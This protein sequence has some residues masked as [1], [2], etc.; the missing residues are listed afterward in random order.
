MNGTKS[1][2]EAPRPAESKATE[3]KAPESGVQVVVDWDS[4][5]VAVYSNFVSVSNRPEDFALVFCAIS[6][7]A[8][9]AAS[10][11][12]GVLARIVSS[13]RM[14]PS[15]LY[16]LLVVLSDIWNKGAEQAPNSAEIPRFVR[17][18]PRPGSKKE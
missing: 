7:G 1:K 14:P 13:V 11:Q 4:E 3:S 8:T 6:P 17:T 9:Q 5:P 12:G 15:N 18:Q 16:Q 10:S 2:P